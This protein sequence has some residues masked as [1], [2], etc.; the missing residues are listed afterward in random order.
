M[1]KVLFL[2]KQLLKEVMDNQVINSYFLLYRSR[3]D[4]PWHPPNVY[5]FTSSKKGALCTRGK[6]YEIFAK[7]VAD[8]DHQFE[9]KKPD[10][11][12]LGPRSIS[13]CSPWASL[14]NISVCTLCASTI[15]WFASLS[16]SF[17]KEK[18]PFLAAVIASTILDETITKRSNG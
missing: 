2:M 16:F 5:T 18:S 10:V 15:A 17:A 8:I 9:T 13:V 6:D 12:M 4:F 14:V 11:L 1:L 7:S 3:S